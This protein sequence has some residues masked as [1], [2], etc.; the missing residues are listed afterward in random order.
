MNNMLFKHLSLIVSVAALA[1]VASAMSA[2]AET[3]NSGDP[4]NIASS[5]QEEATAIAPTTSE[6]ASSVNN[7]EITAESTN[8]ESQA[9]EARLSKVEPTQATVAASQPIKLAHHHKKADHV[10]Q[11]QA[12]TTDISLNA[13]PAPGTVATTAA[14]LQGKATNSPLQNINSQTP[15]S[16]ETQIAQTDIDLGRTTRGGSSYVGVAGNIG[17]GGETAIGSTNFAVISKIG[18]TRNLAV[19]PSAIFGG[20]TAILIPV[21]YDFAQQRGDEDLEPARFSPYAGAG[22]SLNTGDDTGLGL[23]AT[24]GVDVPLS[25]QYTAT[26]GVNVSFKEKTD[27]GLLLGVGYNFSGF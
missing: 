7:V 8:T 27:V 3:T 16:K 20:S 13:K 25:A 18:L 23:I 21:T 19:R 17:L 4:A 12:Q 15:A 11:A 26:A 9:E 2:S 14:A 22:V 24:G 1:L 6:I 10:L 5:V